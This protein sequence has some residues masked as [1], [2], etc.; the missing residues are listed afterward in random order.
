MLLVKVR[1]CH[2][3]WTAHLR[4]PTP[5]SKSDVFTSESC[6]CLKKFHEIIWIQVGLKPPSQTTNHW[7]LA[8]NANPNKMP[9]SGSSS[10]DSDSE[11]RMKRMDEGKTWGIYHGFPKNTWKNAVVLGKKNTCWKSLLTRDFKLK[12]LLKHFLEDDILALILFR[13]LC[14]FNGFYHGKSVIHN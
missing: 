2:F 14:F 5:N 3:S 6:F 13:W 12:D 1:V 9:E 8:A 4:N 7:F 11:T 10:R